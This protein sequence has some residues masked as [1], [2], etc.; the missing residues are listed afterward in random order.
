LLLDQSGVSVLPQPVEETGKACMHLV[1]HPGDAQVLAAAWSSD[2][3][4]FV[5]LDK[6]HFLENPALIQAA[7]FPIG[8]PG[9]FLDW[10]KS[11]LH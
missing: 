10:F 4:Y 5:T 2:S 8:I 7:P 1:Q 6:Q 3:E 11:K 9:D